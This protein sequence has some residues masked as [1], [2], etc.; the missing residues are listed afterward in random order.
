MTQPN[1]PNRLALLEAVRDALALALSREEKEAGL[2]PKLS[3]EIVDR[4]AGLTDARPGS[5]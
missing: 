1:Q 5:W 3:A 4:Y 2:I